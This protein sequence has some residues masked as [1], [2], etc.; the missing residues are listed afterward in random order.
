MDIKLKSIKPIT[1]RD[2]TE[3]EDKF[4]YSRGNMEI[5]FYEIGGTVA[6]RRVEVWYKEKGKKYLK[7]EKVFRWRMSFNKLV[8]RTRNEE[9]WDII[10]KFKRVYFHEKNV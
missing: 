7:D 5:V 3:L 8:I 6:T 4:Y 2:F 9:F 10:N 1:I